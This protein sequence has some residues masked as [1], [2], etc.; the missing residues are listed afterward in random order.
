MIRRMTRLAI[1]SDVHLSTPETDFPDEHL[2][3]T[4]GVLRRAVE[5]IVALGVDRVI[6][7][8]D[9]VNMGTAVEYAAARELLK[10]VEDKLDALPGNHELVKGTLADFRREM[11]RPPLGRSEIGGLTVLR[12]NTAIEGLTPWQWYGRLDAPSVRLLNDALAEDEHRPLLVF[13]HHPVAGTVRL[14]KHPMMA[15]LHGDVLD[16][17]LQCRAGPTVLFTG[18]THVADVVRRRHVTYVGCPPLGFWPHAFLVVEIEGGLMSVRTERGI[19]SPKDSGDEKLEQPGYREGQEPT[20]PAIT[21][22]L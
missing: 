4:G 5:K 8:G 14:G 19:E 7:N 9:L 2:A 6:V 11:N 18:H 1:L 22:R 3:H 10:P 13:C 12:L 17:R 16:A 21:L 15:Q 20:V